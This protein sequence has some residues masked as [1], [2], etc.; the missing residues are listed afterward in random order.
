MRR[1][2][3]LRS[4]SA[5]ALAL[6]PSAAL[7]QAFLGTPTVIL[8]TVG[9]A[10][11]QTITVDSAQATINWL[12]NDTAIGGGPINFLPAGN[13][14]SF[15][16]G[17]GI[18]YTVLNRIIAADPSRAIALNGLV[19][20][21]PIGNVWF[22]APG[23]LLIGGTAQFDVGG[24]LLT[25][26]DPVGAAAGNPFIGA[27]NDFRLAA[28]AGSTADVSI[29]SGASIQADNYMI[30][31]APR[32]DMSGAVTLANLGASAALVMAE[33]V[34]FTLNGGLFDITANV[35]SA[36]GGTNTVNGSITGVGGIGGQGVYSR[37]Y[38]MAVPRNVGMTLLISGGAQLGFDIANAADVD[39]NA[40]VLS[41]G[42]DIAASPI[43]TGTLQFSQGPVAGAAASNIVVD[44]RQL[45]SN[46]AVRSN[47]F[48]R[49]QA[50]AGS[51][52]AAANVEIYADNQALARASNG[53]TLN[54]AGDLRA[55]ASAL[56]VIDNGQNRNA[57]LATVLAD[58]GGDI[59]V[60]GN[61]L[62]FAIGAGEFAFSPGLGGGSG[63]GGTARVTAGGP[64]S[65]ITAGSIILDASGIGGFAADGAGG[66]GTGGLA[67]LRV[68]T[69]SSLTVGGFIDLRAEGVAELGAAGRASG[70]AQGG[71]ALL[72]LGAGTSLA[73]GNGSILVSANGLYAENSPITH[74][75]GGTARGG[76][77]EL[78]LANGATLDT[79]GLVITADAFGP[80][81]TG[82]NS[83]IGGSAALL[84]T[85]TGGAT[86]VR[87]TDDVVISAAA[88]ATDGDAAGNVDGGNATGG[89]VRIIG[90][91]TP[92][93]DLRG[94][95]RLAA[96]AIGGRG[97][98]GVA[99]N[100]LGGSILLDTGG[101]L[102]VVGNGTV[103]IVF[104]ARGEGGGG[105]AAATGGNATGGSITITAASGGA[106]TL[107][108]S[109]ADIQLLADA[110]SGESAVRSGNATGGSLALGANGAITLIGNSLL[111]ADA[112]TGFAPAAGNGTGG[113]VDLAF[114]GG[115]ALSVTGNLIGSAQAGG[116]VAVGGAVGLIGGAGSLDVTGTLGLFADANVSGGEDGVQASGGRIDVLTAAA[117]TITVG[118]AIE[119]TANASVFGSG[120]N[121]VATGGVVDWR[122]GGTGTAGSQLNLSA[123]AIFSDGLG[124]A[125]TGG[126]VGLDVQ[127]GS[128]TGSGLFATAN[129]LA[130]AVDTALAPGGTGGGISLAT[131]AGASLGITGPVVLA[132]DGV[133]AFLFQASGDGG[134]G[135]GG[136]IAI[137][138]AGTMALAIGSDGITLSATGSGG[139]S[140]TGAAGPGRGGSITL[141]TLAGGSF[142]LAST[143]LGPLLFDARGLG[144]GFTTVPGSVTGGSVIVSSAGTTSLSE[145]L[146][147]LVGGG[148]N[149]GQGSLADVTAGSASLAVSGGTTG[150]GGDLLLDGSSIVPGAPLSGT[151]RGGILAVTVTGGTLDVPGALSLLAGGEGGTAAAGGGDG[152]G[153][154]V[155]LGLDGGT[156][157]VAGPIT[158]AAPGLGGGGVTG[159]DGLA[160]QV[161]L[162][163]GA[164][165]SFT[166]GAGL[167]IDLTGA[168]GF[169]QSGPGGDGVGGS[170]LIAAL[171]GGQITSA[172]PLLIDAAGQGGN[173]N[174]GTGGAGSGGTLGLTADGAG[175]L[176]ALPGATLAASGLGGKGIAAGTGSGGTVAVT[177]SNGGLARVTAPL[178]MTAL[179][180]DGAGAPGAAG[181][182]QLLALGGGTINLDTLDA[183]ATGTTATGRSAL[184]A[185]AGS[186]ITIAGNGRL[187][188]TG[189]I[190]LNDG[191]TIT[192]GGFLAVTTP[193]QLLS[194]LAAPTAGATGTVTAGDLLLD[195]GAGVALAT[196]LASTG[197]DIGVLTAGTLAVG[198]LVAARNAVLLAGGSVTTGPVTTGPVT[199]G[200]VTTGA[201]TTP[202]TGQLFI[203]N[204]GQR[205]LIGFAAG[206]PPDYTALL[207]DGPGRVPGSISLL[208]AVST[209]ALELDASGNV[210]FGGPLN[211]ASARVDSGGNVTL[212][213]AGS[214]GGDLVI[215]ADGVASIAGPLAAA[216]I[217]INS[218]DIVLGSGQV[219]GAGTTAIALGARA[220]R[221]VIGGAG[222]GTGAGTGA[223]GTYS[224]SNTEFGVLRASRIGVSIGNGPMTLEELALPAAD[225]TF[226]AS[227]LIRVTGAVTMPQAGAAGQIALLSE[228][229]IEV[230]QGAGSV[231]LGVDGNTPAGTLLLSAPSIRVARDGL[232]QQ[233]AAGS[234]SGAARDAALNTG[235]ATP[236]AA[237][238]LGAGTVRL[239]ATTDLLI[240]NSG[241]LAVP[242]GVTAGSGGLIVS[243]GSSAL[244]DMVINGRI[245]RATGGFATGIDTL[246]LVQYAPGIN[247]MAASSQVNGCNIFSRC[248]AQGTLQQA[249]ITALTSVKPLTP[250]DQR[251]RAALDGLMPPL[252]LQVI[253][254]LFDFSPLF[255]DV[256]ATDPATSTGNPALWRDPAP[257]RISTGGQR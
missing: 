5:L 11:T 16:S 218:A 131:A 100:A 37:I 155:T 170:L 96:D 17:V 20:S 207:A 213:G 160:G 194:G 215:V 187:A 81:G 27:A 179:G 68:A 199:T 135:Q 56:P 71:V 188:A 19:S 152:L 184:L 66:S 69:G 108:A 139:G 174:A 211:A 202:A 186:S 111:A 230:V 39:G 236:D 1:R 216:T 83:F 112:F 203:G 220:A 116:L 106:I 169:G 42:Y 28:S 104:S 118:D 164:G 172:G 192:A 7:A 92:T 200:P 61:I 70:N 138:N 3:H 130:G 102:G 52:S 145:G 217:T 248:P 121:W 126:T 114:A 185:S 254:T 18:P 171:A 97:D 143:G 189:D 191:G 14:V 103:P 6:A 62:A 209:G 26:N 84:V 255:R 115:G 127:S 125:A 51:T 242:G 89:Q 161:A 122:H 105:G 183:L 204:A 141:D 195:G 86:Q 234:L 134:A 253:Q 205:G 147:L 243:A 93:I 180:S 223:A 158:L 144:A 45:T 13:S 150:I 15:Q 238:S 246:P 153:G 132:A 30:A 239:T 176:I 94:Q 119:L 225:V 137:T 227:G 208:G 120:R 228:S 250:P 109:G 232:L 25:T 251:D 166:L 65:S 8:G 53:F 201:V 156:L 197:G 32:V 33:D 212:T 146:S 229:R 50:I 151:G 2:H 54:V 21:D 219:G 154:D 235:A 67:E 123:D 252:P 196:G 91:G 165:N 10:S 43:A 12:P 110:A 99:G 82:G 221:A 173:S 4:A 79:L 80:P 167:A 148:L 128:L 78:R 49:V 24:L 101:T 222:T 72:D 247:A 107:D 124:G 177:A 249:I 113:S 48:G 233:L 117:S 88:L 142:T 76:I 256:D 257:P 240:Q 40:I 46:L 98:G 159:G 44:N 206:S 149:G 237:G 34:S 58:T 63:F 182:V 90:T 168:G 47:D 198:S 136:S 214:L 31:V 85:D 73:L 64:G 162:Q 244:L 60:G 175:S 95:T 9:G 36:A 157:A 181:A 22:Y 38:M 87:A 77:A 231:R 163:I 59:S 178:A 133:G 75:A 74:L 226:G 190:G 41:G 35:G 23:G 140:D 245:A 241:S 224:L 210:L 193:G 57:S 55:D 129:A 29:L